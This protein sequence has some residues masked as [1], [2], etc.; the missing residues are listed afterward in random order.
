VTGHSAVRAPPLEPP[1]D[2]AARRPRSST[3]RTALWTVERTS[4][5]LGNF[6][7]LVVP[8]DRSLSMYCAFFHIACFMIV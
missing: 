1:P 8:Y 6:C 7:R 3:P 2:A 5:W 4:A